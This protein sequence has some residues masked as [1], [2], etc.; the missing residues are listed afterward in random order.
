MSGFFLTHRGWMDSP[1]F[2][3]LTRNLCP[4]AAWL[5][6]IEAA[7]FKDT[8]AFSRTGPIELKRGQ[9]SHSLRFMAN[10][11][12]WDEARV[13]RLLTRFASA[14]MIECV[15][16]AGQT[17]VTIC[18]Y[19]EYQGFDRVGDAEPDAL[20]TQSRR[21][22][23]A[24]KNK[25][26]QGNKDSVATLLVDQLPLDAA[27]DASEPVDFEAARTVAQVGKAIE[28][29]NQTFTG[30]AIALVT[31]KTEARAKSLRKRLIEDFGNDLAKW[32]AY[33]QRIKAS[34]FLMGQAPGRGGQAAWS[35]TFDWAIK[36]SSCAKVLDGQYD[37][38]RSAAP[39]AGFNI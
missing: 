26:K 15:A 5:W 36:P 31:T 16:A 13:R 18:N 27:S 21:S 35:A 37:N 32:T 29:W 24:K 25:D 12:G 39:K 23:D 33:C 30:T 14:K 20:S 1:A 7:A 6:M 8:T 28:I 10:A 38:K 3:G 19:E 2:K 34:R 9:F 11:W 17:V 4:E 22:V